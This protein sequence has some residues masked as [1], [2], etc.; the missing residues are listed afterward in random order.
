[1]IPTAFSPECELWLIATV[2]ENGLLMQERYDK[3]GNGRR[4]GP[5]NRRRNRRPSA[6]PS[7]KTTPTRPSLPDVP[8]EGD[9]SIDSYPESLI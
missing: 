4:R 5:N 9:P 3:A 1:M 7:R 6:F 8:K 2:S